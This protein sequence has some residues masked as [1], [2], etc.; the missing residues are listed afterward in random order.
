MAITMIVAARRAHPFPNTAGCPLVAAGP[1]F[2]SRRVRRPGRPLG[3][4]LA[5]P[6]AALGRP[7]GRP[8]AAIKRLHV[9]HADRAQ[10]VVQELPCRPHVVGKGRVGG[11]AGNPQQ[12]LEP[13]QDGRAFR[14]EVSD[15]LV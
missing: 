12:R 10:P 1:T 6:W 14:G 13:L 7:V 15:H 2:G 9:L 11:D 3:R 8:R 5:V 4:P